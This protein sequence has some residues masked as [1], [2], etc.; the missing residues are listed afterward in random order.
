MDIGHLVNRIILGG[1]VIAVG[2]GIVGGSILEKKVGM[3]AA[4]F[5]AE[6]KGRMILAPEGLPQGD[7]DT[8]TKA[9]EHYDDGW[10]YYT[11]AKGFEHDQNF[12]KAIEVYRAAIAETE[13][14]TKIY[15]KY[16]KAW[17]ALG[18][19]H[20]WLAKLN[21]LVNN[22]E[23]ASM[24]F[25]KAKDAL[26]KTLELDTEHKDALNVLNEIRI[27]HYNKG[28]DH[29]EKAEKLKEQKK[30]QA[31]ANQ[32]IKAIA[33]NQKA[34][35]MDDKDPQAWYV[36]AVYNYY[37]ALENKRVKNR[38]WTSIRFQRAKDALY[39]TLELEQGH[40]GALDL[41]DLIADHQ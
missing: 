17:Y 4:A 26:Y 8:F 37:L 22:E 41:L 15:D 33:E 36:R 9:V 20:Y 1:T 34:I 16:T 23:E 5:A 40:K 28:V 12:E 6:S 19:Y 29:Y 21:L 14:A 24:G 11:S 3:P 38:K 27:Y 35:D 7:Y 13:I 31:A 10:K 2:L 30:Y 32:Y 18:F 39:K 25:E